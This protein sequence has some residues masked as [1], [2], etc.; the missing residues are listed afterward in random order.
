MKSALYHGNVFHK[1]FR[2]REH[3]LNYRVF[4]T[5]IDID[6]L[7]MLAK[8]NIFFSH[9][10]FNVFSFYDRDYLD[11]SGQSLRAQIE[12]ALQLAGHQAQKWSI[13]VLT[14]P[15]FLGYVFNPLSVWFCRD[16]H[17]ELKAILYEVSNTFGERHS[18]LI[19][20]SSPH[21]A[22]IRQSCAKEFYVSPFIDMNMT[23][24]FRV[25]P[26][27]DIVMI[28]IATRDSEGLLLS[29]ILKGRKTSLTS[30]ALFT[31]AWL[32][33]Y[34]TLKVIIAIH[35]EALFIWI[36]GAIF[37]KRPPQPDKAISIISAKAHDKT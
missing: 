22:I 25:S 16:E 29:A 12:A 4:W 28:D 30:R 36:K 34:L 35:W 6:E 8:D 7:D 20:V 26:P 11:R 13:C 14:M 19:A 1:R 23:Y 9:N 3:A 32:Y 15:R 27:S 17:D 24:D 18:Y 10:K 37:Y 33:P 21:E 5:Y 31:C 2:P